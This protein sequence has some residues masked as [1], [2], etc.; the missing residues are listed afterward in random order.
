VATTSSGDRL[1]RVLNCLVELLHDFQI[2]EHLPALP[3]SATFFRSSIR[4]RVGAG[5]RA[6]MCNT[7]TEDTVAE[8]LEP[9]RIGTGATVAELPE[10][11]NAATGANVEGMYRDRT[12]YGFEREI[13][14]PGATAHRQ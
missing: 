4:G 11:W 9:R 13:H 3:R 5:L 8:E 1:L 12:E 14:R 2:D 10:L 6:Q 7:A